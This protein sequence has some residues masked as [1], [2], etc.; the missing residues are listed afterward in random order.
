MPIFSSGK[1]FE[2]KKLLLIPMLFMAVLLCA[3]AETLSLEEARGLALEQNNDYQASLADLEAARWSRLSALSSFLPSMTLDGAWLYMDPAQTVQAGNSTITL[4]HDFRSFG[5]SLSQPLFLGGKLWQAYQMAKVGEDM[6][7]TTLAAKRL[8]ILNG[9]DERYLAVLQTQNLLAMAELDL[10][11]AERNLEIA[12]LKYDNGLLSSADYLRFKGRLAS[13]EV[14]HLQAQTALQMSQLSLR[15]Y[16]GMD[17]L[18]LVEELPALQED[19]QLYVLDSY[20]T[21]AS[22]RLSDLALQKGR[23]ENH[24]LKLLENSVELSRRSYQ[25]SKGSFLPTL[26]LVASRQYDENGI[27]RYKFTPSD[28]IML[29]AS[30]PILPQLGNYANTRKAKALYSKASLQARTAEL[31]ILMGTEAAVLNLVSAA[32][33]VQ[34]A[35]LALSYTQQSYE[36]LQERFRANLIS[37]TEL[38]DAE[39]MLSSARMA[40]TN[41][42][43]AYH[44]ARLELQKLLG[45]EDPTTLNEMILSGVNQ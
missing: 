35:S 25:L 33:Q 15:D 14:S 34:A 11:S 18:P 7:Q 3:Q 43:F 40:Y 39:L 29:T 44:K 2:L 24:S 27:D 28:Q 42:V 12:Q 26:M 9:T 8:E 1:E 30:L 13:K 16:L 31:G 38:L 4:N 41:S 10:E 37:T 22:R 17:K 6:A 19:P 5:F 36:Q 45:L 23:E 32:K 21:A 20:D